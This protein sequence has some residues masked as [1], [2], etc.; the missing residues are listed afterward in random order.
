MPSVQVVPAQAAVGKERSLKTSAGKEP[1]YNGTSSTACSRDESLAVRKSTAACNVAAEATAPLAGTA[2]AWAAP[3]LS[4][5]S[6]RPNEGLG[7]M[8]TVITT[9][10]VYLPIPFDLCG[11]LVSSWLIPSVRHPLKGLATFCFAAAVQGGILGYMMVAMWEADP[12][13]SPCNTPAVLQLLALYTFMSAMVTEF[14]SIRLLAIVLHT[15][16]LKVP[17]TPAPDAFGRLIQGADSVIEVRTTTRNGRLLLALAPLAELLIEFAT[18]VV[19]VVYLLLS[20][21]IEDLILNAVA[22]NFVTQIDEICLAAYVNKASRGRMGKYLVEQRVGIED[23]DTRMV[24]ASSFTKR[25][26]RLREFMPF[27]TLVIA[28]LA[29]TAGQIYGR[30]G[31]E[32]AA[33]CRWLSAVQ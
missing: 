15:T 2:K 1:A 6:A 9:N 4:A 33:T 12:P 18:L 29:L 31:D 19:G 32:Q 22:V 8:S 28:V 11:L 16:R 27:C 23:G 7:S 13:K 30:V 10:R 17:G 14:N 3:R 25:I 24:S 20:D 26:E 5:A 21:S